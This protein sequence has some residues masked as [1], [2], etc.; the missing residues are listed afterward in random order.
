MRF[1]KTFQE[2]KKST[3]LHNVNHPKQEKSTQKL[4]A[5]FLFGY[6]KKLRISTS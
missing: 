3:T 6:D 2:K 4:Y 5:L 1:I